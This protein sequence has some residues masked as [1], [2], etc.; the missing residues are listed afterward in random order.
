MQFILTMKAIENDHTL[1]LPISY[2]HIIQGMIYHQLQRDR[3]YSTFL[4]DTGYQDSDKQFKLF[5]FGLLHG[6]YRIHTGQISFQGDILLEIRSA[7]EDFCNV[8]YQALADSQHLTICRQKLKICSVELKNRVIHKPHIRVKMLS[9]VTVYTTTNDDRHRSR[10][11]TPLD[12]EF[13]QLINQN[14]Q[15]KYTAATGQSPKI[16]IKVSV[17]SISSRDKYVTKFKNQTYITA[18]NGLFELKGDPGEL[19]FLYN[20]GIGAKNSQ[21]FGMFEPI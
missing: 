18:W 8:L 12:A 5:T 10:Y 20:T 21:G 3:S 14:F 6:T 11:Y 16:P 13:E 4:H 19:T 9:P 7:N 17:A 1:H 2:H 15:S